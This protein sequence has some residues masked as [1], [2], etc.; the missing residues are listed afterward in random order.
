MLSGSYGH[1]PNLRWSECNWRLGSWG[2]HLRSNEITIRFSP[3]N[4]D[5]IDIEMHKWCQTT[6]LIKLL[7]KICILTHLGNDLT[8]TR[9]WPDLRSNSETDPSR[10]KSLWFELARQVEHDCALFTFE[11]FKSKHVI[12]ETARGKSKG[13][14]HQL[15]NHML[16]AHLLQYFTDQIHS[17]HI[18][19]CLLVVA[20]RGFLF[21]SIIP[22]SRKLMLRAL[23]DSSRSFTVTIRGWSAADSDNSHR[24][25]RG[26]SSATVQC[27][28]AL[29]DWVPCAK[30]V[31]NLRCHMNPAKNRAK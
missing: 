26:D 10:S 4:H 24:W 25:W 6:W 11:S 30:P 5:S 27:E 16:L 20:L 7:Q 12:Y 17:N 1:S 19:F 15:P 23:R 3:I 9:P 29:C 18:C 21:F 14:E 28:F 2:G 13:G 8:L 31:C 22:A